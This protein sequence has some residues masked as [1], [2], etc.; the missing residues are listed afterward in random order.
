MANQVFN[1]APNEQEIIR[2]GDRQTIQL[3]PTELGQ[4]QSTQLVQVRRNVPE[5][6]T[7]V[8]YCAIENAPASYDVTVFFSLVFGA[9]SAQIDL[10]PTI[11]MKSAAAADVQGFN[12]LLT[13][14][15]IGFLTFEI[16]AKFVL[17]NVVNIVST[18][19]AVP[20][21]VAGMA[22]PR[23]VHPSSGGPPTQD[24][25]GPHRVM[26]DGFVFEPLVHR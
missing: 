15:P 14:Q 17:V 21:D 23:F 18:V 24:P 10:E 1:P 13:K 25:P 22:A 5:T 16:P 11:E 7:V 20:V 4:V 3:A 6:Y 9:G 26:P 8:C 12:S 19:S 2:W